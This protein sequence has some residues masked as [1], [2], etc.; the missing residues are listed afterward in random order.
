MLVCITKGDEESSQDWVTR[1]WLKYAEYGQLIDQLASSDVKV[2]IA[3]TEAGQFRS[4]WYTAGSC[5]LC[6][7]SEWVSS[8]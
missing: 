1:R 7:K 4:V 8:V 5:H 6:S 2:L 3:V